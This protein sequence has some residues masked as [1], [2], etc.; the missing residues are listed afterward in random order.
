MTKD[1]VWRYKRQENVCGD[2]FY[3]CLAKQMAVE[4][5]GDTFHRSLA[6]QKAR[7]AWRYVLRVKSIPTLRQFKV[8]PNEP[9]M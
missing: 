9:A 1:S 6:I 3:G 8:N 2:R 4:Y 7:F 5:V